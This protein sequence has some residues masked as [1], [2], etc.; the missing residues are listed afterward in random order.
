VTVPRQAGAPPAP[1]LE[2][3]GARLSFGGVTSL[4]GVSLQL[5]P[6]VLAALIGPNGAGKTSLLN[7][8]SGVCRPD[9]GRVLLHARDGRRHELTGRTPDAVSRLGV[10]R[11]FQNIRLFAGLSALDN[12]RVG[13]DAR[14]G[15]RAGPGGARALAAALARTP[16]HR[17]RERAAAER[18]RELLALVGLAGRE[19]VGAAA[20]SYGEQRRLEI[21]RAL[22]ADPTLLLVDEPAA[23]ANHA[24]KLVLADLL[25]RINASGVTIL[26]IEHDM[27]MVASLAATVIVLN[28]GRVIATGTPTEIRAAAAVQDAYLGAAPVDGEDRP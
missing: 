28:F 7:V 18:A 3:R 19:G 27:P 17:R 15:G 9:A 13:L 20:L 26:M 25:R 23:G 2:V 11:T 5:A 22:G 1:V 21:A 24:E 10:A 14:A 8:I 12:V 4:D 6:G 16:G